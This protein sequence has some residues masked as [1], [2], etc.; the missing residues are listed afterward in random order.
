MTPI[1]VYGS[2]RKGFQ[3]NYKLGAAEYN[4]MYHTIK[5]Y[6]MVGAK[7]GAYPYVVT[8]KLHESLAPT[9]I[10][11]ELYHVSSEL[12]ES[13]DTMEGA[14]YKRQEVV[15]EN[16]AGKQTIAHMYVVEDGDLIEG[17]RNNFER[18][19]VAINGGNWA[20]K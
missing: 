19:F 18:R 10:C 17:I 12:L 3:N 4:G 7:S 5:R 1:F 6:Y 9:S 11:G 2:L 16:D 15:L 13:L 20:A 8:E 14:H